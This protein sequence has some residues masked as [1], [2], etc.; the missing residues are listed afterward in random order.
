VFVR[1]QTTT[2]LELL[3]LTAIG[4]VVKGIINI[5]IKYANKSDSSKIWVNLDSTYLIGGRSSD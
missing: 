2:V 5:C 3:F 1:K 4:G